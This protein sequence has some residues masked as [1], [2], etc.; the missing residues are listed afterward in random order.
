MH[1]VSYGYLRT[2]FFFALVGGDNDFMFILIEVGVWGC[3]VNRIP[4]FLVF[5]TLLV[6]VV[7]YG[8]YDY[9]AEEDGDEGGDVFTAPYYLYGSRGPFQL[10]HSALAP[11]RVCNFDYKAPSGYR[12]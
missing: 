3:V 10:R 11:I 7:G 12:D 9:E 2:R 8:R 6:D 5:W 4:G 1:D